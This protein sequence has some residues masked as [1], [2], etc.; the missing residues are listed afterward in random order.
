MEN[1][2]FI[3]DRKCS[4]VLNLCLTAGLV[5]NRK[6]ILLHGSLFVGVL[7]VRLQASSKHNTCHCFCRRHQI[8]PVCQLPTNIM[9][10]QIRSAESIRL[11]PQLHKLGLDRN[12][13][14]SLD[15]TKPLFVSAGLNWSRFGF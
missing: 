3:E 8:F 2:I 9:F 11:R 13:L 15:Q 4:S 6:V 12:M 1:R 10:S 14:L 7:A 5:A